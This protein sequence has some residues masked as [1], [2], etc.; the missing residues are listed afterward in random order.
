MRSTE[1]MVVNK[2]YHPKRHGATGLQ[3]VGYL[4]KRWHFC[5]FITTMAQTC[6]S[7]WNNHKY[8]FFLFFFFFS[9]HSS[10][11]PPPQQH[12]PNKNQEQLSQNKHVGVHI[13]I[14]TCSAI[15]M[16]VIIIH[17]S[18]CKFLL[19]DFSLEICLQDDLKGKRK[20]RGTKNSTNITLNS[21]SM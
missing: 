10:I 13:G 16:P 21:V 8:A 6:I 15:I 17:I 18:Q 9:L 3:Y 11:I 20:V 7:L 12:K 14:V 4:L 2:H 19:S 1:L 5:Y